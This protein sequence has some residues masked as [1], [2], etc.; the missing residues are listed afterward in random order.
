MSDALLCNTLLESGA[1]LWEGGPTGVLLIHGYTATTRALHWLPNSQ[2]CIIIDRER[3]LVSQ[4][5][6]DF[7]RRA[8][9]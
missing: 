5:T 6:L 4:F 8:D 1:F 9:T 7:I 2:H 3:E